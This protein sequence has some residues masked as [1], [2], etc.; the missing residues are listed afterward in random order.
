MT[1]KLFFKAEKNAWTSNFKWS[2]YIVCPAECGPLI[3]NYL[4]KCLLSSSLMF[5]LC[6]EYR[7]QRYLASFTHVTLVPA[8]APKVHYCLDSTSFMN[9]AAKKL[10]I[11]KGGCFIFKPAIQ[12]I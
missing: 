10:Q 6:L 2:N 4:L 11:L 12:K 3:I 5:E 9:I 7:F 8:L 1:L